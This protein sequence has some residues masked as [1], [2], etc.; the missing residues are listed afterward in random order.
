MCTLRMLFKN[1]VHRGFEPHREPLV[2]K[3]AQSS[4]RTIAPFSL[5]YVDGWSKGIACQ[6]VVAI[7]D[8]LDAQT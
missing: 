4:D 2:V 8:A 3:F 7:M 6:A 5:R 1:I